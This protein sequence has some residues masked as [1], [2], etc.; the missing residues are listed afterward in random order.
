MVISRAELKEI[1]LACCK[2]SMGGSST[3][4]SL[5]ER[6][7]DLPDLLTLIVKPENIE[8]IC[9]KLKGSPQLQFNFLSDIGGVDYLPRKPRFD[10]VYHLYSIPF[11]YR[12]RIKCPLNE[13]ETIPSVTSVWKTADW[14]ERE[15]YDMFG[16]CFI[17][18]PNLRR[19][20]MCEGYEGYPLRKDYPVR[21][22][23]DELNPFGDDPPTKDSNIQSDDSSTIDPNA[24][25][26]SRG[27]NYD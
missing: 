1:L 5:I 9:H 20:Y 14:H 25:V 26:N 4:K 23:K 27:Q 22:Y 18:H 6:C 16:I 24:G 21:G 10:V 3:E 7:E 8:V 13:N 17:G 11:G 2:E 12:I 19:I 15:A